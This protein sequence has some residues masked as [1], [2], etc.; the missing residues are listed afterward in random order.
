VNNLKSAGIVVIGYVF[1]SYAG[2]SIS[3]VEADI[4]TYKSWYGVQGVFV[5][6]MANWAGDEWY[7]STLNSYAKSLG[8]SLTVGNPG[9]PV[10]S[11]YVGTMDCIITYENAGALSI[12]T[13]AS[14]TMG[15]PKSN[16]GIMAY[17]IGSLDASYVASASNYLGYIYLTNGVWPAPY[18]SLTIYFATLVSTLKGLQGSTTSLSL[19]TKSANSANGSPINGLWTVIYSNG[20]QVAS[21]YTPLTFSAQ[22]GRTYVVTVSD[23]GRYS[24]KHWGSGSTS[25]SISITLAQSSVALTAY[26]TVS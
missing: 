23:Y 25:R 7:Y 13:M 12:S 16:W 22:S 17:G 14:W 5:D 2:R 6:Q 10:P 8:M 21:G 11:S 24:F 4:S 19:T 15:Y 20:V 3:G 1:S 18:S 9:A 26:Y